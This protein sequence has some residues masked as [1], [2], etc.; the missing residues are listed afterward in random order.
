MASEVIKSIKNKTY[1]VIFILDLQN[2]DTDYKYMY[3]IAN[4]M[5]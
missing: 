1:L 2:F 4:E 3:Y 5:L